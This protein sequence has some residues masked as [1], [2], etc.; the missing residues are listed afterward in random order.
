MASIPE[1]VM[2][3]SPTAAPP[4]R[5]LRRVIYRHTLP[6]RIMHW[7]NAICLLILLGSG[8]QIFNAHPALYWGQRSTFDRPWLSLG[9]TQSHDG[10]LHGVTQLGSHRFDSTGWF[11]V[12]KVN[13][14]ATVRGFPAWATIPGRNGCPW[15]AHGTSSSHGFS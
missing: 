14:Q 13:G 11:G 3:S 6:L 8:L 7:I 9:A 12:S 5:T 2:S 10:K 1:E 15:A 4:A